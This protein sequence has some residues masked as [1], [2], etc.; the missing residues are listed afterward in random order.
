MVSRKWLLAG[1]LGLA[2]TCLM[3]WT[4]YLHMTLPRQYTAT[5]WPRTWVG[6]D[7]ALIVCLS[8][9]ARLALQARP[10]LATWS[11]ISATLL[12]SDAWFDISTATGSDLLHSVLTAV[13]V[14]LP[15]AATLFAVARKDRQR[16]QG[17]PT[18]S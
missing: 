13:L 6:F 4:I 12:L 2:V 18:L 3:P 8:V 14:E 11:T 17:A 10:R 7:T 5:H 16:L 1:A 15:L 9:T